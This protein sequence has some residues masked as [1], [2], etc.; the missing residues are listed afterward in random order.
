MENLKTDMLLRLYNALQNFTGTRL[1]EQAGKRLKIDA[2]KP[3]A[4]MLPDN[5]RGLPSGESYHD[6]IKQVILERY[7]AARPNDTDTDGRTDDEIDAPHEP[8]F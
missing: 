4:P 7:K 2:T 1:W 6:L 8:P 3:D 5:Y